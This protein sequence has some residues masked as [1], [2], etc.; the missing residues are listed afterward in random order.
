MVSSWGVT[1]GLLFEGHLM[2]DHTYN[3]AEWVPVCGMMSDLLPAED[4]S[5]QELSNITLLDTPDNVPRMD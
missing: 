5:A 2:Y 1:R 4:S 3:V